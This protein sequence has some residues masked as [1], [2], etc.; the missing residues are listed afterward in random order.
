MILLTKIE[1]AQKA[2]NNVKQYQISNI[3]I[4]LTPDEVRNIIREENEMLLN[5]SRIVATEVAQK[6]L[7]NYTEI[8]IPKLVRAEVLDAFRQ[9]EIQV[10]YKESEKTAICTER[11]ADYEMLSEL[12]I[13]KVQK[14][15]DYVISAAI[16]KAINE[17]NNISEEALMALTL[18]F[19]VISYVPTSGNTKD[20]LKVLDDLYGHLLEYFSLPT[21]DDWKENLGLV[22][23]ISFYNIGST[24]RLEDY[25]YELLDGY[26]ALGLKINS[27]KHKEAIKKLKSR[28]LPIT[29]LSKNDI[30]EEYVRLNVYSKKNIENLSLVTSLNGSTK[31]MELTSDQKEMLYAIYDSYDVK[32]ELTKEKITSILNEFN[33]IKTV[34]EWWN[35][36]IV[37]CSFQLTAIGRVLACTNAVRIDSS[38]PNII[39][40]K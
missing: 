24:K 18:I 30:D 33:N 20:G 7:D 5:S 34:I 19:S 9:P 28:S 13:H 27:E 37:D 16:E 8:L 11:I 38:L 23:A 25:F 14:K 32:N 3:N 4:G 6:R 40:K 39:N 17:I 10:L 21:T 22:N 26:S 2:R 15:E 31:K 12:L 1:V 36:H 35:S 29:I